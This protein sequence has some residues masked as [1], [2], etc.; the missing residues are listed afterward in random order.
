MVFCLDLDSGAL[1]WQQTAHSGSVASSIHPKNSFASATPVTDGERVY[2]LF[3]NLGLFAY[4]FD[5]HLLWSRDLEHR[6]DRWGWG[7]GSSPT[8][9]DDQLLVL[10]D[11]EEVSYLASFDTETGADNW[12]VDRDEVSAWSTPVV[13]AAR[14][15]L[16]PV[17]DPLSRH[18]L[19]AARRR[20][21]HRSQRTDRTHRL[22][23]GAD[24][25]R[26]HV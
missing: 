22:R 19:H 26:R 25:A 16:Q 20:L 7:T 17:A 21:S 4:D 11:N 3:G 24:R 6:P 23:S 10:H 5:G 9:L 12:R 14:R 18:L 13:S 2:A 1:L 15:L 8:L